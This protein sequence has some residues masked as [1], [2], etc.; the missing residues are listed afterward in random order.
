MPVDAVVGAGWGDEG[1]GKLT[2]YLA[3]E[4]D[5]VVRFQGGRNAGHSIENEWGRFALHLLPSGVFHPGVLNVLGPG[6]A[7]DVD[8]LL[9]ELSELR[10]RGVP[11]PRLMISDR[12]QVVL[13]QH[14]QLDELEEERLGDARF[15]STRVGIAP[16]YADKCL[17]VGIQVADLYETDSLRERVH[18]SLAAKNILFEHLYGVATAD[19]D[20][21]LTRLVEM[22]ERIRPFVGDT[23]GV[24][25]AALARGE[26]ILAEGQLGALRDPD[27]GVYPWSTSSSPLAGSACAGAGLP[28]H[29]FERIIAVTKAYSTCVGATP[30]V[31]EIFGEE[32]SRLRGRGNEFGAT[33]GRPRRVGWLDAV[34]MRHGCRAQG[35]SEIA[36]TLLDV[37]DD[38][39]AIPICIAYEIDGEPTERFPPCARLRRAR[40]I[41]EM[42]SGWRRDI[43]GVQNLADLPT[44]ARVYV[45]RVEELIGLPVRWISVGPGRDATFA[46]P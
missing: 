4:A 34:A 18:A 21:L 29:A 42:Q 6:V 20:A 36:L 3:A 14:P 16:F 25:H 38:L 43:S 17:K 1:K 13:P 44:A 30:F 23:D 35:A 26:R 31:T 33:T 15:G 19:P 11:A 5:V 12:T 45:S 40:P 2:D 32:A 8:A 27:H 24:L 41:Y 37:L 9:G 10:A 46:C 39:D 22:G 7:L 28:P